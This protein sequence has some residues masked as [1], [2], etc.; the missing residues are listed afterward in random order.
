MKCRT[1]GILCVRERDEDGRRRWVHEAEPP[2][3]HEPAL[4]RVF[5]R[6]SG[7]DLGP[8]SAADTPVDG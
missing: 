3:A 4:P 5:G 1:C 8:L 7:D 6:P 2:E